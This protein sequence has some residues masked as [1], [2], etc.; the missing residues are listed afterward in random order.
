MDRASGSGVFARD[1]DVLLDLI[2]LEITDALHKQQLDSITRQLIGEWADKQG[3]END[4]PL[5]LE[6]YKNHGDY[7]SLND[8]VE[9]AKKELQTRTAWRIEGTLREF[10]KFPPVNL[11][12]TYPIHVVDDEDVL[13]DVEAEGEGPTWKRNFT[14]K[15]KTPEDRKKERIESLEIAIE[16]CGI[17]ETVTVKKLAEYLGKSEDTVRNYIKE[18]GGYWIDNGE[19]GKK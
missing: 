2:E 1:P 11:W 17:D 19:V 13:K 9:A 5:E 14:R 12:F 6:T 7:K 3:I 18:H 8:Q 16:A 4:E 15:K 10:P